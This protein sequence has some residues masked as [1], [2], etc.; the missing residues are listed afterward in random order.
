MN[1]RDEYT[2]AV[3]AVKDAQEHL[4]AVLHEWDRARARLTEVKRT[5]SRAK[6]LF[7]ADA[8][9]EQPKLRQVKKPS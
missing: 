1:L 3:V 8:R 9:G 5:A 2:A 7:L 4:A 6:R